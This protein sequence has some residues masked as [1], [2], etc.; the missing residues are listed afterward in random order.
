MKITQFNNA[1]SGRI[2]VF[3]A[4]NG[5]WTYCPTAVRSWPSFNLEGEFPSKELAVQAAQR[6][7]TCAGLTV[8]IE[9]GFFG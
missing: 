8:K 3:K 1:G 2:H 5:L 9:S 6:D 7:P 4:A